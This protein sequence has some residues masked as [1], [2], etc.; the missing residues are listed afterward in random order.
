[1]IRP[2]DILPI[3][4]IQFHSSHHTDVKSL[5]KVKYNGILVFSFYRKDIKTDI[6]FF[7]EHVFFWSIKW[8][9]SDTPLEAL[10]VTE[11]ISARD[12]G[13]ESR[14]WETLL[15][16]REV[17]RCVGYTAGEP[18][19]PAEIMWVATNR[20]VYQV[21]CR[22]TETAIRLQQRASRRPICM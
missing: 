16:W 1:M 20:A 4:L 18:K 22:R 11:D 7:F 5:V 2:L 17:P 6:F 12:Q 8:K 9:R 3:H 21:V 14:A 10:G 19:Q 15:A 13:N